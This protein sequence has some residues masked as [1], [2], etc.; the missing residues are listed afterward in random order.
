[1]PHYKN[2]EI[3]RA[4]KLVRQMEKG[5]QVDTVHHDN[6]E[7]LLKPP[8]RKVVKKKVEDLGDDNG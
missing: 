8:K 7:R 1:V 6:L 3:E 5:G 4:R 2:K